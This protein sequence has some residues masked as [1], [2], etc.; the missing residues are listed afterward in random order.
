MCDTANHTAPHYT[1]LHHPRRAERAAPRPTLPLD[2]PQSELRP[3][4]G[5]KTR[6]L[7]R[8]AEKWDC[9]VVKLKSIFEIRFVEGETAAIDA[10]VIDT[11]L[12]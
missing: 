1:T 2:A 7:M 4:A 5:T 10:F 8:L 6:G 11:L 12:L 9:K 3:I